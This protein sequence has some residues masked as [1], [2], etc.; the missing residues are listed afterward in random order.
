MFLKSA[1]TG[2]TTPIISRSVSD[3]SYARAFVYYYMNNYCEN[4]KFRTHLT[5]CNAYNI[6]LCI[7]I[8][9]W[10]FILY[11]TFDVLNKQMIFVCIVVPGNTPNLG[12]VL[13][14]RRFISIVLFAML[15][16]MTIGSAVVD[17]NNNT[18]NIFFMFVFIRLRWSATRMFFPHHPSLFLTISSSVSHALISPP[19]DLHPL[20]F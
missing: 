13:R 4:I 14:N 15:K 5:S 6:I 1:C 2:V 17:Y 16:R 8:I 20:L 7:I 18:N 3:C 9:Q 12:V 10:I 11:L 19:N